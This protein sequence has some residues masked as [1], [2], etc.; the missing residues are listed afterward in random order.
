MTQQPPREPQPAPIDYAPEKSPFSVRQML[1]GLVVALLTC[2]LCFV[3]MFF[4]GAAYFDLNDDSDPPG[5]WVWLGMA[6]TIALVGGIIWFAARA[7]HRRRGTRGLLVGVLLGV[8]LSA[9]PLG[10][11]F[12]VA[13]GVISG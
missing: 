8:G 12:A 5:I 7:Q 9:L 2:G 10:Y 1:G 6:A 4:A 11:C 3:M 13:G